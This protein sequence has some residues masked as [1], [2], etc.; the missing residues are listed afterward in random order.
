M[1]QDRTSVNV[2]D[3]RV[4]YA[5][6]TLVAL[7]LGSCVAIVVHDPV[8]GVGG[9]AHVLLP[10]APPGRTV[11]LPGRYAQSAIPLLIEQVLAAGADRARL[12]GRLAGGAAMFANLSAPGM[13]H[14]GER[15]TLAA[16]EALHG[17]GVRVIGEWVGGDFGR[18]VSYDLATGVVRVSSVRHGVRDL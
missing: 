11:A 7:G 6:A 8:A 9:M 15:N 5:P 16:R 2:A 4:A 3:I 13:I 14:M 1:S 17:Q 18:S 12:T 10:S